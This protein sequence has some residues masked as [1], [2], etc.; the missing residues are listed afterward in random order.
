MGLSRPY[1]MQQ[2]LGWAFQPASEEFL[3]T[4]VEKGKRDARWAEVILLDVVA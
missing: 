4:L 1:D 3:L 2:M